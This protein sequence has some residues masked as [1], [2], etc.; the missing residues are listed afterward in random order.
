MLKIKNDLFSRII[1]LLVAKQCN[2]LN[3][4]LPEKALS[5]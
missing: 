2:I 3:A 4:V 1:K 5:K